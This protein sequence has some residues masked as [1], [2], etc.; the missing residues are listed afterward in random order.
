MQFAV[1]GR[2]PYAR[3]KLFVRQS[4]SVP[5]RRFLGDVRREFIQRAS[6]AF[7]H[8]TLGPHMRGVVSIGRPYYLCPYGVSGG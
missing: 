5:F 2:K 1:F 6:T 8:G 7:L 4:T 3:M